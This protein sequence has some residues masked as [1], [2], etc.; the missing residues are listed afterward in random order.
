MDNYRKTFKKLRGDIPIG[1]HIH[2]LDGRRKNN[3]IENLICVSPE[4]HYEIH[5][6]L[7]SR[8]GLPKD[9]AAMNYLA[10]DTQDRVAWNKGTKGLYRWDSK[11][12]ETRSIKYSGGGNPRSVQVLDQETGIYYDTIKTCS[13]ANNMTYGSLKYGIKNNLK[14]YTRWKRA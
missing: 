5:A 6:A 1:W 8:Y 11:Q 12:K 7:W 9:A 4:M 2:H 14:K 10:N 13:E 3:S